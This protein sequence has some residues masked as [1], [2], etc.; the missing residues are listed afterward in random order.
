MRD[1]ASVYTASKALAEK[2]AWGFMEQEPRG[3]D[4]VCVNPAHTWGRYSQHLERRGDMNFTNS[5]LARLVDGAEEVVPESPV[6]W[7]TDIDSVVQAHVNALYM[8]GAN[9]RYIIA[10][11]TYDFQE[12]VDLMYDHFGDQDWIANVPRGTPG[13]RVGDVFFGLDNTRSRV[14]LGVVYRPWQ[15][16]VLDFC[17]KYQEDRKRFAKMDGTAAAD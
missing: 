10:N 17:R 15:Q 16:C 7:M 12:V 8:P 4:L 9:R 11:S 6:R 13:K 2:A 1:I 14:E 5:D 3:F